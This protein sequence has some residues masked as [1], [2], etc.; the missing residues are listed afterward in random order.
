M[1]LYRKENLVMQD[2]RKLIIAKYILFIFIDSK[3]NNF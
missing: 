1:M 2:V 3:I